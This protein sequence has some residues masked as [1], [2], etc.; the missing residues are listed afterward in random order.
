M[1]NVSFCVN[2]KN[3]FRGGGGGVGFVGSGWI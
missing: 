3:N 1:K 2:S